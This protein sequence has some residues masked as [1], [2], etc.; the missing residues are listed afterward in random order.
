[1][2]ADLQALLPP[3]KGDA[4]IYKKWAYELMTVSLRDDAQ[5]FKQ[6]GHLNKWDR[7]SWNPTA[8]ALP[9]PAS[10]SLDCV[11]LACLWPCQIFALNLQFLQSTLL[12]KV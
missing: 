12:T 6:V 8:L 10:Y 7:G 5:S 4:I 1:M 9:A 2:R 3:R 11:P